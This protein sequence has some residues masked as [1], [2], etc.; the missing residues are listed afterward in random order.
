MS[1]SPNSKEVYINEIKG[2]LKENGQDEI[3]LN[4]LAKHQPCTA[5]HLESVCPQKLKINVITRSLYN[6]RETK[7]IIDVYFSA[8]C[9]ITNRKAAYYRIIPTQIKLF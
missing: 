8:K 2:D 1:V 4:L 3:I 6:L 9:K 7:K 5:I